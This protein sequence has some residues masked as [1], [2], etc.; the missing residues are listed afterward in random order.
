M[1]VEGPGLRWTRSQSYAGLGASVTVMLGQGP[2]LCWDRGQGY[3]GSGAR[4]CWFR[5]SELC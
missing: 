3:A 1:L 5:G 2:G 4:L